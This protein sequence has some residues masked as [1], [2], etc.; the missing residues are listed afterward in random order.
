M[1]ARVK[2][3]GSGTYRVIAVNAD[4]ASQP[5]APATG[6]RPA[7]DPAVG[8]TDVLTVDADPGGASTWLADEVSAQDTEASTETTRTLSAGTVGITLPR[9]LSGAG[10]V[11][12]G[13][14]GSNFVLRQKDAQCALEGTL[15][16]TEL[17]YT[18]DLRV[19]TMSAT[20]SGSCAGAASVY[21]EIRVKST[22][23]F[24]AIAVDTPRV[25]FGK[26]FAG[27][28]RPGRHAT[29]T[30]V[31]TTD[32]V[33]SVQP[34]KGGSAWL[35][36]S[37][38]GIVRPGNSCLVDM[39]LTATYAAEYAQDVEILDGT[40]RG[41]RHVHFSASVYDRP[42]MP[43]KITVDAT[44]SGV[45]LSW[46]PGSW[47]NATP[48]GFVVR[49][50]VDGV[51]TTFEVAPDQTHWTEPWTAASRP[52]TYQMWAVNEFEP[53]LESARVSPI[54]ASEQVTAVIRRPNEPAVL[55]SLAV[56]KA[57]QVVPVEHAPAGATEVTSGPNGV[58]V[59]YVVANGLWI[60][61]Q[62]TDTLVRST[63]GIA[64]PAWSPDGTR[65][66]FSTT[67]DDSTT[68]VDILTLSDSSAVRVGCNLDHPIW[69]TDNHSLIVQDTSLSG[70]PLARVDAAEQ[71]ARLSV[72][73]GSEGATHAVL[74]PRGD[75]L[76]YV[77]EGT[78]GLVALL[79]RD[80][81]TATVAD[82]AYVQGT[83]IADLGWDPVGNRV[84]VLTRTAG[85]DILQSFN[86][87]DVLGGGQ[88]DLGTPLYNTTTEQVD[89]FNWQGHNVVIGDTPATTGPDV[90]IP[91]D[92]SG[93]S[94]ESTEC[95]LDGESIGT[96]TSPFTASGLSSGPH[97]LQVLT[98]F[99]TAY[100]G[101]ATRTFTVQ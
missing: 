2:A 36:R 52:V 85:R 15:N 35:L 100:F 8:T 94:V 46:T 77:P 12:L 83:T 96:C 28:Q 97:T 81:G 65:I 68:C 29:L 5:S 62:G 56:P 66:A 53:S 84:A 70:S 21:G 10:S 32:L 86:V 40:S 78:L 38:C 64:H 23:P 87:W 47:G 45:D 30:N 6:T 4:G 82:L 57:A 58:D 93:L 63:P 92:R 99:G 11:A 18:A 31:G 3:G 60:R 51:D 50:T 19:A 43:G 80:G 72:I 67:S 89:D 41:T 55:G 48:V 54:P 34:L 22:R 27:T 61:Q 73:E 16:V 37:G 42:D 75:W 74:S 24:A 98:N 88:L 69:H 1:D 76:A 71:G 95:Y 44:Y 20:Y 101:Y 7:T 49:R 26:V 17:A 13:A 59:A 91:F 39:S 9:F 90:S 79:P 25:D 33:L 14:N